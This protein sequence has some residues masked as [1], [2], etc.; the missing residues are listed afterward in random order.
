MTI[1]KN[2]EKIAKSKRILFTTPSHDRDNFIVPDCRK[3]FGKSFYEH[4]LS[5]INGLDNLAKP[6]N[7]ILKAMEKS[8]ELIGAE[9]VFYLVNGSSSGMIAAMLS[10]LRENDRVL[11]ARNCHQSVVNGLIL[12]GAEPVWF[13]PEINAEWGIFNPVSPDEIEEKL[14]ENETIK[15]VIIT[16][17]TYEGVTS[18]IKAIADICHKYNKILIVDEAHGALKSFCPEIFGENAVRLGADIAIQSLHKTCGA[19]NPCAILLCGKNIS[20]DNIQQS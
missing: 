14:S 19:P 10:V 1:R 16:S 9:K 17:P 12:T 7:S 2:T 13:L 11:V 6:E 4:D 20:P 3:I 8:A 18:D 15:A 5:E